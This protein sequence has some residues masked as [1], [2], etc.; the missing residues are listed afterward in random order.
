MYIYIFKTILINMNLSLN[1]YLSNQ[2]DHNL[3]NG[4]ILLE[5][6]LTI[7]LFIFL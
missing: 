4:S 6:K 2:I 5:D 7:K 1:Y 3:V